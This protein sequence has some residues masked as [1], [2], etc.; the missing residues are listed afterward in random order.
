MEC[1][2]GVGRAWAAARGWARKTN[3]HSSKCPQLLASSFKLLL[4]RLN[5]ALI[6]VQ[7]L[8]KVTFDLVQII[9]VM[10]AVLTNH[11]FHSICPES[12]VV[13]EDE[14]YYRLVQ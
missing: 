7:S 1:A 9:S 10:F 6:T 14:V 12:I 11:P 2:G 13:V 5:M 8:F 3:F 4:K